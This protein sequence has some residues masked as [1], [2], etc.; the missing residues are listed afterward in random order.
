MQ[1]FGEAFKYDPV[2]KCSNFCKNLFRHEKSP[3]N[4]EVISEDIVGLNLRV[5][6]SWCVWGFILKVLSIIS[7]LGSCV[8]M[9]LVIHILYFKI[10]KYTSV[11]SIFS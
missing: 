4:T 1:F 2:F 8:I 5:Y 3:L 6:F 10:Q 7:L 9:V 11:Q